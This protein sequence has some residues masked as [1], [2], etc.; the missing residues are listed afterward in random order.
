MFGKLPE[1]L[2]VHV[3]TFLSFKEK[4]FIRIR[5]VCKKF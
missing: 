4:D 1:E 3:F 2:V 5:N